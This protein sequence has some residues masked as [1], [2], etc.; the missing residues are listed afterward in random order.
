M[1][2]KIV[3]IGSGFGGLAAAIRLQSRGYEVTIMEKNQMV[4]GHAY[5]FKKNGY[6]FD[7]GPSLVTAPDII[8][9]VFQVAGKKMENYL[10]LIALDPFYRIYFHDGSFLDYTG[11]SERMKAQMRQFN[12]HDAENY[13]RFIEKTALLYQAVITDGL[14]SK[15]FSD[16]GTM[17]NFL[18]QALKLNALVSAYTFA[19]KYFKDPR[20]RFAFSFHPLFIGGSPFRAPAVYQ[21]IPYLEKKGGVWFTR[22]GM[23]SLV[24]AFEKVFKEIGGKI[25]VGTEVQKIKVSRQKVEGVIAK[26]QFYPAEVVISNADFAHTYGT[27]IDSEHRKKWKNWRLNLVAYSM[28]A[29]LL[30]LGVKKSY[31]KLLHHTLI[32]SQ[33]YKELVRDIFDRKILPD[34]FSMYLHVPTRTDPSMAP[35]GCESMYILIPVANLKGKIDWN[36]MNKPFTEKVIQF[37]EK[38][39]GLE[40]LQKNIE[41]METFTPL[42]FKKSRNNHL[43]SAWGVEPRLTQ[44][45]VFRPHNKSEDI[46]GL[47]L[48]GASTHPGA[49]V[50]GVLLTAET[51]ENVIINDL[52]HH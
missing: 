48:V 49:G 32:L 46:E 6:T 18:P 34:D 12:S 51:T 52:N 8:Q 13:D 27:L 30:Y 20:H 41:V 23:Y 45:A 15:P 10:D 40:N 37:L 21:M 9:K 3:V 16:W 22:G 29:Y 38:D 5:Q 50:P 39:F 33:R 36:T 28:S 47:Y 25:L 1:V 11:D 31:P 35:P 42:D 43:G 26:D 7:M 14:G 4:G 44:T 17:L 19:K 2:K 24:Q